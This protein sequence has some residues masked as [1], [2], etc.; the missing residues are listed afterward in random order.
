M[1]A[2]HACWT[3][4]SRAVSDWDYVFYE[5]PFDDEATARAYFAKMK[6]HAKDNGGAGSLHKPGEYKACDKFSVWCPND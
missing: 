5:K 4:Q 1:M 2:N 3:F 6:A